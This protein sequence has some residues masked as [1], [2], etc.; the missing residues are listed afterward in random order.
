MRVR[1]RRCAIGIMKL[2]GCHKY[3]FPNAPHVLLQTF[4]MLLKIALGFFASKLPFKM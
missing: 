4:G 1:I 2:L 3:T